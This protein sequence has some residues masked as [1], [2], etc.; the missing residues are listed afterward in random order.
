MNIKTKK[1]L[2]IELVFFLL[3]FCTISLNSAIQKS[4]NVSKIDNVQE[5]TIMYQFRESDLNSN[6]NTDCDSDSEVFSM[7]TSIKAAKV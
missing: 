1:F 4:N 7:L 3:F 6:Q 5:L 2:L